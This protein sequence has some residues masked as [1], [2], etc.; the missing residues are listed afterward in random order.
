M[1]AKICKICQKEKFL[2]DFC[3]SGKYYRSY[4]K[5]CAS[6]QAGNYNKKHR[7]RI[8][9]R[10]FEHRK[11]N[12]EKYKIKDRESQLKKYGL[13][14]SDFNKKIELQKGVCAICGK[15]S[16]A[17]NQ[18]G[19]RVLDVDHNHLNQQ[20]RGLLCAR[21]NTAIGLL[22]VDIFGVLNLEMAI[23]YINKYA[24]GSRKIA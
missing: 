7:D 8:A 13:T 11:K 2:S 19:A 12:P 6:K 10:Q 9:K 18:Y 20:V 3:K 21:C 17:K 4:C 15:P 22:D 24:V 23:N 14:L 5:P 1:K 16:I